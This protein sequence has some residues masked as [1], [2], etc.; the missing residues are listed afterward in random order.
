MPTNR[1]MQS[2][3]QNLLGTYGSRYSDFG[4]YWLFGFLIAEVD[5]LRIDLLA[6][7]DIAGAEPLSVARR[8]AAQRFR[9]QL[10]KARFNVSAVRSSM[11]VLRRLSAPA[12]GFVN[13]HASSGYMLRL[14][15]SATMTNGK[16]YERA[17][18]VFVAPH[19][20]AKELRS[21]RVA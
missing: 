11:L 3:L 9:E 20:S 18:D 6:S 13:G 15:A 21:A 5:E 16:S 1:V 7:S 12:R 19:D 17:R 8:L 14:T 4:G 2:V 10:S